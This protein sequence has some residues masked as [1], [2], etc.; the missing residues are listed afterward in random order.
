MSAR[1]NTA[2]CSPRSCPR[3]LCLSAAGV[4]GRRHRRITPRL[5][6]SSTA[7][8]RVPQRDH[9]PPAS[10]CVLD[11]PDRNLLLGPTAKAAHPRRLSRPRSPGGSTHR[12]RSPLQ[13][14]R[15]TVRLAL[16]RQQPQ[17]TPHQNRCTDELT[18]VTTSSRDP[19][20]RRRR[21]WCG[22]VVLHSRRGAGVHFAVCGQ[23]RGK[24]LC[25]EGSL[26]PT[27]GT[28]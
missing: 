10:T 12:V 19:S 11:Q 23:K 18:G 1:P 5:D 27:N 26:V 3:A 20:H 6:R 17:P 2:G 28:A 22:R 21:A 14:R 25:R 24:L 16:Q 8:R 9:D 7:H 15:S 13:H 4:L